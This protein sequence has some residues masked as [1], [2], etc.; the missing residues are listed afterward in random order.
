MSK[1]FP[2][3][4]VLLLLVLF[5]E[6]PYFVTKSGFTDVT[7]SSVNKNYLFGFIPVY[8]SYKESPLAKWCR[9]HD[10]PVYEKTRFW[11]EQQYLV[12]GHIYGDGFWPAIVS[13]G[14]N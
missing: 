14:H 8:S 12:L 7:G 2:I 6:T 10:V 4:I 5:S 9:E 3:V 1:S 11:S 13:V